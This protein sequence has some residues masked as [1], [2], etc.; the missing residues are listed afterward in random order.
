LTCQCQS[1]RERKR[2]EKGTGT[3]VF[4]PATKPRHFLQERL[5]YNG[6]AGE[7]RLTDTA[8]QVFAFHGFAASRPA[9]QRGQLKSLTDQH[10][11]VTA[12]A[13][14]TNGQPADVKRGR[15]SIDMPVS[16]EPRLPFY[17]IPT[18]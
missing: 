13:R 1:S 15:S 10:G 9:A 7:F 16:I 4:A 2:A 18:G 6:G 3:F 12:V 17:T 14:A 11:H 8:G 5:T